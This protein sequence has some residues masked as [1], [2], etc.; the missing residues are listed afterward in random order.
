MFLLFY[1][2][3]YLIVLNWEFRST[4]LNILFLILWLDIIITLLYNP[5][6][7]K[8]IFTHVLRGILFYAFIGSSVYSFVELVIILVDT[9]L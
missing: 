2:I 8:S 5:E 9:K 6:Y 7:N 4:E 3:F 1:F